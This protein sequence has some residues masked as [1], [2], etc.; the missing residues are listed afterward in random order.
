MGR[1]PDAGHG[2]AHLILPPTHEDDARRLQHSGRRV[3]PRDGRPSRDQHGDV[4]G[5]IRLLRTVKVHPLH[6]SSNW[7]PTWADLTPKAQDTTPH[8]WE[9]TL[10]YWRRPRSSEYG[11]ACEITVS[12]TVSS[13]RWARQGPP[14]R[15]RCAY[16]A[17]PRASGLNGCAQMRVESL[18]IADPIG[19]SGT[20]GSGSGRRCASRTAR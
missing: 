18:P 9:C 20:I 4:A 19:L 12:T 6:P 17:D 8:A 10:Q 3:V 13:P 16:E 1:G 2:G 5:A 14:L 11:T 15:A 7:P